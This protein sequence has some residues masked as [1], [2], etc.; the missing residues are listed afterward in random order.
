MYSVCFDG[1]W[2]NVIRDGFIVDGFI[3]EDDAGA[4]IRHLERSADGTVQG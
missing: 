3:N 2:W 1:T 4:F